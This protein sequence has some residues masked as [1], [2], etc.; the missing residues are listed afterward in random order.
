MKFKIG[1]FYN[2]LQSSNISI[3]LLDDTED[4]NVWDL[5]SKVYKE[6]G[7]EF[8]RANVD[9]SNLEFFALVRPCHKL[10]LAIS[11]QILA[12]FPWSKM[13]LKSLKKTFQTMPKMYQSNQYSLRY[14][15]ISTGY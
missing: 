10:Y 11:P 8:K 5:K 1:F 6:Y 2:F 13:H 14:Q 7:T 12:W 15:L 4:A 9:L 3:A